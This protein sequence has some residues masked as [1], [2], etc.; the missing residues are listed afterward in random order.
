MQ[1]TENTLKA[2]KLIRR[3]YQ[4]YFAVYEEYADRYKTTPI[5][6]KIRPEPRKFQFLNP[7]SPF[8]AL[9]NGEKI[10]RYCPFKPVL[11]HAGSYPNF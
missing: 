3:R 10:P 11:L 5:S 4:E 8:Y 1:K 7:K 2:Y 9:S 6:A